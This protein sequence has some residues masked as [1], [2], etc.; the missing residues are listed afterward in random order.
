MILLS[1]LLGAN[2]VT[3]RGHALGEVRE[4]RSPGK[5]ETEPTFAEREIHGLLCGRHG[6]LER[7]GWKQPKAR[8]VPWSAVLRV[9]HGEVLV[10]GAA[11]DY[12]EV[13]MR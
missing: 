6:L 5:A 1:E 8:I 9:E 10:R 12:E 2:A 3:E 7:L 4:V 11:E 13:E